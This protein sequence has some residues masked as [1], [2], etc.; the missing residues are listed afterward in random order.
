MT[1]STHQA[2]GVSPQ[3]TRVGH[4]VAGLLEQGLAGRTTSMVGSAAAPSAMMVS[5]I[6]MSVRPAAR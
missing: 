6:M 5:P 2:G 1:R 3:E 4:R